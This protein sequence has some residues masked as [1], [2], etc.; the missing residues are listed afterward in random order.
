MMQISNQAGRPAARLL[1]QLLLL[2]RLTF[3]ETVLGHCRTISWNP[4]ISPGEEPVFGVILK[5]YY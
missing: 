2:M 3:S 5:L 4:P 1:A